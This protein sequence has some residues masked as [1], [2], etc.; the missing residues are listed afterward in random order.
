LGFRVE[1][2]D[3]LGKYNL[4]AIVHDRN[5]KVDLSLERKIEVLPAK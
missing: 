1:P 5:A 4:K 2:Q 3:P